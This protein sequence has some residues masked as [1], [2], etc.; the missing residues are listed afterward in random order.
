MN[1][2]SE[3][4]TLDCYKRQRSHFYFS[5]RQMVVAII[6]TAC[7]YGLA[8]QPSATETNDASAVRVMSFNIRNGVANDGPNH[9]RHRRELVL[10]TVRQFD[11]DVLGTQEMMGFQADYFRQNL[12]E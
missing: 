6:A 12:P 11:P 3:L 7:S 2:T 4:L 1:M 8:A 9:W 10:K 5:F